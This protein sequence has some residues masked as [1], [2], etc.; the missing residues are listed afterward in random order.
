[1]KTKI[2]AEIKARRQADFDKVW[3]YFITKQKPLGFNANGGCSYYDPKTKRKCAVGLLLTPR[4]RDKLNDHA[5]HACYDDLLP[6]FI[7]ED[8][9][10]YNKLQLAHDECFAYDQNDVFEDQLREFA[11]TFNLKAPKKT[12]KKAA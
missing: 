5:I 7:R 3:D 8:R 6:V 12:R 10:F 1:M 11:K 4:Q 9:D 2:A